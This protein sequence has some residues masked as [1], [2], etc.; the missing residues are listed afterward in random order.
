[1]L[2]VFSK[3]SGLLGISGFSSDI[4][5]IIKRISHN[6]ADQPDLAF[7]MYV[8]RLKK[9]IGSFVV[10]LDGIDALIFTDDIG[11]HNPLV[12]EKV[13]D[14]MEWCGMKID[15]QLNNQKDKKGIVSISTDNSKVKILSIPT[16]EELVICMEELK[17]LGDSNDVTL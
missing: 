3:R 9:Y 4:R 13:C 11:I 7:N 16:D 6:D 2:D 12:R 15:N 1:M 5:D 14:N 10:V 17:L 8:H